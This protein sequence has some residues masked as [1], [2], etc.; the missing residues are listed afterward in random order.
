MKKH[1]RKAKRRTRTSEPLTGV[2]LDVTGAELVARITQRIRWH[3]RSAD[4][5]DRELRTLIS[6]SK[7]DAR[8]SDEWRRDTELKDLG[9]RLREHEQRSQFLAFVRDHLARRCVYRLSGSDLRM[10]EIMPDSHHW[11]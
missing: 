8:T 4:R 9:K 1:R 3:R 10:M 11:A 6:K 5:I 7:P 2:A